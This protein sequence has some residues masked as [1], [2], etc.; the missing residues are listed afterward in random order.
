MKRTNLCIFCASGDLIPDMY[1]AEARRLGKLCAE[2][3]IDII[4]G[5]GSIG[6]MGAVS[7]SCL[8]GGGRVTGVIPQFMVN[9][10]WHHKGLTQL[11]ITK[12]MA[13]RKDTMRRMSDGIIA[14]P[15]GCGTM[16][17]LMETITAKQLGLYTHPIVALNTAGFYDPVRQWLERSVR[18]GFM[19]QEHASLI[20]FADT[21]EEALD[22]Y[23][24]LPEVTE[25]VEKRT[26]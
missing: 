20:S 6:L 16:E 1:K 26:R 8:S 22:L 5:A 2:R 7:D 12:D 10:D 3:H 14:L 19:R 18:E 9:R 24:Q 13:S 23:E 15:G 17:E 11:L 21:V 4:N 25:P